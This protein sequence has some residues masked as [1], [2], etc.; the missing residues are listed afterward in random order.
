MDSITLFMYLGALAISCLIGY[1]FGEQQGR[2]KGKIEGRRA[3]EREN[4]LDE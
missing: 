2:E 3:C 1:G 4:N